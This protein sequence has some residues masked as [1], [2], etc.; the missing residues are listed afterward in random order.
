MDSFSRRKSRKFSTRCNRNLLVVIFPRESSSY[1]RIFHTIPSSWETFETD[2]EETDALLRKLRNDGLIN[3]HVITWHENKMQ[4]RKHVRA[5]VF[6]REK[7]RGYCLFG[8]INFVAFFRR[9]WKA[10]MCRVAAFERS[11][12]EDSFREATKKRRTCSPNGFPALAPRSA[13]SS[14]S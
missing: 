8:K 10:R 9:K 14:S 2:A 7:G 6:S 4:M 1:F 11:E 12:R 13:S 3:G 5:W